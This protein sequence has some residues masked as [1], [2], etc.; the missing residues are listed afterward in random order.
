MLNLMISVP[1]YNT[2]VNKEAKQEAFPCLAEFS[3]QIFGYFFL[4]DCQDFC[5]PSTMSSVNFDISMA[6]FAMELYRQSFSN[7]S[8]SFFSPYSIVLTLAMTYFGSSGRTKQQLKDRLFSVSDDQLQASLDGI[9]QSLQGD[10]HQQEQLTMQLHLANRLFARNNLK[11]LPAYLTRIQKTF[12]ADVDLVDFSNGAAAAEKINRWVANETKDRIKNLIP[13]DVL[14]E[15]T[16]LVL[17]NAIYFKGNWQTRFAPES[18]SKQYFSVDQNTNKLVDMM[19]VNDTFRHAE[20]EQFQILQL[21]YESSKLAMY[22]LL[23]KEKF[24]LEKLVNQLSGEQLLD[25]MEAVTSKKVSITFPKFKL[26]ETLPLKKILLQLGLTSMFDHSM[27]DF[28]MMTGD[29]SVIVSDAFHKAFIE[30]NEEGSEAS[31]ATAVVAMLRSAQHVAPPA[32]FIADHPFMFL[33][34]DMQTQTILFMGSYR[35]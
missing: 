12:K 19:H 13:P 27:A 32:V 14:D 2:L 1:F 29:R 24:G 22:V 5:R 25:S 34:A 16:C 35:G 26:E 30:V 6:N 8:N 18:T 21:P 23:P 10:Q 9:F 11:L 3:I 7:Q 15:M 33:I 20:H 17:V 31:A 28:S 4:Q